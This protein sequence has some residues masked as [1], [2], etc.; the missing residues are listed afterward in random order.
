MYR[1]N[2]KTVFQ[3]NL[4]CGN[5]LTENQEVMFNDYPLT[6][7][8][9]NCELISKQLCIW[10]A[11]GKHIEIILPTSWMTNKTAGRDCVYGTAS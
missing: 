5:F 11:N 6:S 1:L 2:E 10:H 9:M 8:N 3:W 4:V 7:S